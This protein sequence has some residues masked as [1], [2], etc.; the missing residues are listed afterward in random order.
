M[1]FYLLIWKTRSEHFLLIRC[2]NK[3]NLDR[4]W[5][6]FPPVSSERGEKEHKTDKSPPSTEPLKTEAMPC[7][8]FL[9][10]P[11]LLLRA[12]AQTC[13]ERMNGTSSR[14]HSPSH[15]DNPAVV[16]LKYSFLMSLIVFL[17]SFP[18]PHPSASL[19]LPFFFGTPNDDSTLIA[20]LK[21]LLFLRFQ[22]TIVSQFGLFFFSSRF[23]FFF[24]FLRPSLMQFPVI[25]L[26]L[27][28]YLN[29]LR[30][31]SLG[32]VPRPRLPKPVCDINGVCTS[33]S[34]LQILL[35]CGGS[36]ILPPSNSLCSQA[37]RVNC[38]WEVINQNGR[39]KE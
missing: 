32:P 4:R 39:Q 8:V 17:P 23:F 10:I 12:V 24:F 33:S 30:W 25:L 21:L 28:L 14:V 38:L 22:D 26:A 5:S 37:A 27:S 16:F 15:R 6:D 35:V 2:W 34:S 18:S 7:P 36:L 13:R 9:W 1:L 19:I 3:I 29:W 31:S 11:P 20:H